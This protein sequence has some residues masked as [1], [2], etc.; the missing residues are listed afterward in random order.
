MRGWDARVLRTAS[1]GR[2]KLSERIR[3]CCFACNLTQC[4]LPSQ[5]EMYENI[6][7]LAL[8]TPRS[9]RTCGFPVRPH[10]MN[11]SKSTRHVRKHIVSDTEDTQRSP[12]VLFCWLPS[13]NET[14]GVNPAITTSTLFLTPK[15]P[16]GV[17]QRCAPRYLRAMDASKSTRHV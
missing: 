2:P 7:F 5:P 9:A 13:R 16:G 17:R 12:T 10:A 3:K 15:I 1:E 8:R 4:T 11:D 14:S 6:K